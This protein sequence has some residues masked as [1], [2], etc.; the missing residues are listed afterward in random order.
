MFWLKWWSLT[1][2]HLGDYCTCETL[3]IYGL[4]R[5]WTL[6]FKCV[7]ACVHGHV[8]EGPRHLIWRL[9]TSD[10]H[11]TVRMWRDQCV[12]DCVTRCVCVRQTVS[13]GS[14]PLLSCHSVPM[15]L[16][17]H[18]ERPE[19]EQTAEE[20]TWGR[21]KWRHVRQLRAFQ[22]LAVTKQTRRQ[23]PSVTPAGGDW[24]GPGRPGPG[25]ESQ[26]RS[27]GLAEEQ[28]GSRDGGGTRDLRQETLK[29]PGTNRKS[30]K[31]WGFGTRVLTASGST[32]SFP[33]CLTFLQTMSSRRRAGCCLDDGPVSV[34]LR[35]PL[36]HILKSSF[37]GD[38]RL[39][40]E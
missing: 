5:I 14:R 2:K 12:S 27:K 8:R 20:E 10:L 33:N 32:G 3:T 36:L 18:L 13:H 1:K 29:D 40:A 11:L 37:H 7:C 22:V 38:D 6:V 31:I 25:L 21:A 23:N 34:W 35:F 24:A 19:G 9:D 26:S 15:T 16:H 39:A 4:V 30:I 17:S 28:E